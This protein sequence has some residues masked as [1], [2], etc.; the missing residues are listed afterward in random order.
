MTEA[1]LEA[2]K[3]D[4][5]KGA[6][7]EDEAYDLVVDF[8]LS[9]NKDSDTYVGVQQGDNGQSMVLGGM[10]E[11][12]NEVFNLLS[13][14]CLKASEELKMIDP[15]INLRVNK[16]T[17][18]EIYELGSRL[19][20]AGL[21]FP[22][23]SND[24]IVIDGLKKLGYSEKDARDYVVAACWEFIIPNVGADIANIGAMS[25]PK[26]VDIALHNNLENAETYEEEFDINEIAVNWFDSNNNKE[27]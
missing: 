25:Y 1:I 26:A 13:K 10:D 9:F 21:G 15:K 12:G 19:T 11:N 18:I 4:L 27:E 3:A 17:P 6:I 16:N 20:K 2:I 24:D 23:Y 8:F 7:T 22:Q 14:M 5:E